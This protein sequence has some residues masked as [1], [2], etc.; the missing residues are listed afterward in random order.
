MNR[1]TIIALLVMVCTCSLPSVSQADLND[2]LQDMFDGWALSNVTPGGVYESQQRGYYTGGRMSV[3]MYNQDFNLLSVAPPQFK[4]GCSGVDLYLGAFSYGS[5]TRYT[6]LLQQ[7]G[8]GLVLGFAFQLALKEICEVCSDVLNKLESASRMINSS[9]RL[10]P[11]EVGKTVGQALAGDTNSQQKVSERVNQVYQNAKEVG[12]MIG[13]I[14]ED[15]DTVKEETASDAVTDPVLGG[16]D[17]D[18]RGNLT[19]MMLKQAGVDDDTAQ[20]I[21]SALGSVVITQDGT[22]RTFLP[23]LT[24]QELLLGQSGDQVRLYRCNDGVGQFQCLDVVTED[25]TNIEGFQFRVETQMLE[26]LNK[27]YAA[28]PL[29]QA[30]AAFISLVPVGIYRLLS[31]TTGPIANGID[32]INKTS[33]LLAAQMA[34]RWLEWAARQTVARAGEL[35]LIRRNFAGDLR[36]WRAEA[37]VVVESARLEVLREAGVLDSFQSVVQSS[38]FHIGNAVHRVIPTK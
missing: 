30:D 16:T 19:W 37:L 23:L 31:D 11:C 14:F 6:D 26:I 29:T 32:L 27:L 10:N 22:P 20:M 7:L 12:G 15:R 1:R 8:T 2:S 34:Y 13:D 25:V 36:E 35:D 17:D 3:R 28:T 5:L 9:G 4:L 18:P 33:R 38:V 21:L 24:F